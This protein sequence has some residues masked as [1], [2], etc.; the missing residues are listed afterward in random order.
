MAVTA[1]VAIGLARAPLYE[2][3]QAQ[4]LGRIK[5]GEWSVGQI[6]P[7]EG[8]LAREFQVSSGTIRKALEVLEDLGI[9]T[10]RQGR[11]TFVRRTEVAA[12]C[13]HCGRPMTGP[14]IKKERKPHG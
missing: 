4:I 1:A 8:D 6:M 10:R 3:V 9:L 7:N 2:Q 12:P 13:P 5:D 14:P 11:G